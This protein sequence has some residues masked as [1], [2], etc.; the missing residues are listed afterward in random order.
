M[1]VFYNIVKD[2][3]NYWIVPPVSASLDD[4]I[5][6]TYTNTSDLSVYNAV[7][8]LLGRHDLIIGHYAS[9]SKFKQV[10]CFDDTDDLYF[11]TGFDGSYPDAIDLRVVD[12]SLQSPAHY[13]VN[14]YGITSDVSS[15]VTKRASGALGSVMGDFE[16]W[17]KI[18]YGHSIVV[19]KTKADV[20]N[21]VNGFGPVPYVSSDYLDYDKSKDNTEVVSPAVVYETD[22]EKAKETIE[23]AV[24]ESLG[25]TEKSLETV[26][27]A[28]KKETAAVVGA[29]EEAAG[30]IVDSVEENTGILEKILKEIKEIKTALLA[31]FSF[32]VVG[33]LIGDTIDGIEDKISETVSSIADGLSDVAS[34]ASE[35]F[36]ASLPWDIAILIKC[37]AAEPVAPSFSIPVKLDSYGVDESIELDFSAFDSISKL[38][39]GMLTLTFIVML[40]W[41]TFHMTGGG[42]DT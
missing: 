30:D 3:S 5:K 36:P 39:R 27:K 1:D 37:L 24:K 22:W 34:T 13:N 26:S 17:Q 11:Y 20:V 41:I 9:Y 7:K 4:V 25:D 8:S 33:D 6:N 16:G 42:G 14:T 32:S 19:W 40:V 31:F 18:L 23:E 2:N 12:S 28:V 35:R 10:Q 29:I 15:F 38:S 21:A